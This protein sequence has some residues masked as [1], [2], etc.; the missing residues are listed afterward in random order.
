MMQ[1]SLFLKGWEYLMQQP[2]VL[3]TK[4]CMNSLLISL[5]IWV[6][7]KTVVNFGHKNICR[8]KAIPEKNF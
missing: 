5:Q 4:H 2:V 7:A 6:S 3:I 1:W 8:D